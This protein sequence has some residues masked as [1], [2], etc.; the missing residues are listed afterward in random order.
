M[1]LELKLYIDTIPNLNFLGPGN[2]SAAAT[3]R[4]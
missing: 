1:Y 4:S 3:C 2:Y